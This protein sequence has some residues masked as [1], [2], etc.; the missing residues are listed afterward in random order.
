MQFFKNPNQSFVEKQIKSSTASN[1]VT[2]GSSFACE[3][4]RLLQEGSLTVRVT[5]LVFKKSAKMLPNQFFLSKV[6]HK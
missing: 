1:P 4:D 2:S 3:N 5:R 6:I